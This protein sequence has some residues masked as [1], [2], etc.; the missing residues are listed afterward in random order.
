M[1]VLAGLLAVV[2]VATAVAGT[3]SFE[4]LPLVHITTEHELTPL[5]SA[6][7]QKVV[8]DSQGFIWLAFYSS[9]VARYD[10]RRLEVYGLEDGL[11]SVTA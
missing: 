4:E 8:Q 11:P 10:G 6:S 1:R 5:P 3:E 2:L 7:V 9:G